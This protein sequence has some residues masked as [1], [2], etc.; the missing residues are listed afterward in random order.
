MSRS[1]RKNVAEDTLLILAEGFYKNGLGEQVSLNPMLEEAVEKTIMYRPNEF[2]KVLR[3]RDA[4]LSALPKYKTVFE[5]ENE[6]TLHA[7]Q[8]LLTVSDNVVCLNFASAKNP[9]GG[10][11]NG[12]Q[13]QEESLARASGLYSSLNQKREMYDYNR[14]EK[15][16]FYSD[17][18]IYSPKLPVFRDDAD[19]LL[20]QPYGAAF[21]TSPAVNV[22]AM[23][24]KEAQKL[25]N[26]EAVMSQRM[27]RVLSLAVVHGHDTL[28]LG[29]WGCGVFGND[30][31]DMA[32][33]FYQLLG[34]NSIFEGAFRHITFAVLD[35]SRSERYIRPFRELF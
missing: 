18:M 28:V 10:F 7:A 26:I 3:E 17:Y 14:R 29:A 4:I 33:Y 1:N 23:S 15:T 16:C 22:G 31:V 21:I 5:V 9:G 34:E 24:K 13:A 27:E 11:L 2:K 30:P 20:D 8:R 6:T 35:N 32:R 19:V 12:S 25:D